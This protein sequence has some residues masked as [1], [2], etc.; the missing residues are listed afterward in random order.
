MLFDA[1]PTGGIAFSDSSA[2]AIKLTDASGG[3]SGI[4]RRPIRPLPATEEMKR[5][6]RERRLER[7]SNRTITHIGGDP[8]P[9]GLRDDQPLSGDSAGGH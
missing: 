9:G 6:E 8:P 5:A 1:L 3:V 4:L 2:Y 7:E